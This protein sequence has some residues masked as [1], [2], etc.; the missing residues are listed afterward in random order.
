LFL[1]GNDK[2]DSS[3]TIIENFRENE[4]RNSMNI[5]TIP[6]KSIKNN[7]FD[8]IKID[9]EGSES[10]VLEAIFEVDHQSIIICE[11]LPVYTKENT[12]RLKRQELIEMLLKKFDYTIFRIIKNKT[13]TLQQIDFFGIHDDLSMSDYVFIPKDKLTETIVIFK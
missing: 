7:I 2:G 10:D 6:L 11:I 9:V 3:A 13:V 4:N 1:L 5:E 12:N 8:L